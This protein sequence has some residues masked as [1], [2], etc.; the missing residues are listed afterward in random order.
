MKKL[1]I[2]IVNWNS[3]K[4]LYE[5]IRSIS[6]TEKNGLELGKV[7][8]V[9]NASTDNSLS[10]IE[11]VKLPLYVIKNPTNRGFAAACNQG[12]E[13]C[14]SD[15]LLFLNPDVRLFKDSLTKPVVFMERK[16]NY[17]IGICGIKLLDEQGIFSTSCARFPSIRIYFGA[18]TGLSK[19]FP[20]AFPKHLMSSVECEGGGV[21]DQ[22]IGA[23]FVVRGELFRNLKGFDERF[24]VYFEEVDFS[25]RAKRFGYSSYLLTEASAYHKSGGCSGSV[26]ATRLFYSLRSRLQYGDKHF[27]SVDKLTLFVITVFLEFG[28]RTFAALLMRRSSQLKETI[29]GYRKLFEHLIGGFRNGN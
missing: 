19:L 8:V 5:C 24:F 27:S 22:I 18:A 1:D 28:S 21:V 6:N 13:V 26:K 7:V 10:G 4:Q 17:S 3:G 20:K 23:F 16:E 14:T 9:D 2:I 15:Y 11:D 29:N 12:A 25:L